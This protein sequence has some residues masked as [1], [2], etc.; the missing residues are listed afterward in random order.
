MIIALDRAIAYWGE[1]FSE[2]GEIRLF[3]G[4]DLKI[5]DI[6]DA[7][8]LVVRSIT[9]VKAPLLEKSSVRFVA[10]ASAGIDHI[11]QTY[12][13]KCGIS[14]GG[15]AGCNANAVSEYIVTALHVIAA[16]RGW[17]LKKK[18]LA[19]I[20][21]GNVG[22]RVLQKARA[23]GMEVLLC[24][25]PLSDLTGEARYQSFNNVLQADILSF[26]VPLTREAPYPT[27]HMI[28]RN[29]LNRLLPTQ[30][31]INSSRG[32]VIDNRELKNALQK[33]RI[34][35]AVLDV[36]EEEPRVDYS[37]LELVDIGTPHLAGTTLDGKI[38]ATE[39]VRDEFC[40]FFGMKPPG[41]MDGL[42]PSPRHISP[43]KVD[44]NQDAILSV[45]RQILDIRRHDADLRAIGSLPEEQAAESFERLRT[46]AVLRPEFTHFIV[47]LPEQHRDSAEAF[48]DLGFK[49]MI[50]R[51]NWLVDNR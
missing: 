43:D 10:A 32:A 35:G 1:A 44:S 25:P 24:D 14:F 3:S 30:F 26:H 4:R 37:L 42:Y 11:D 41:N 20:G 29:A 51:N 12:L 8:A 2:F 47:D 38:R 9:P 48:T 40:R 23:I 46:G 33:G 27:W 45:L 18:S 7:D 5:E 49:T 17:E 21:V 13:K 34:A 36:W 22:S 15:A 16:R 31:L 6:R 39:M 50:E 19:V 28:D